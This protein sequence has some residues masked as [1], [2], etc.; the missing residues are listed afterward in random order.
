MIDSI[1]A[2]VLGGFFRT[3]AGVGG[4]VAVIAGSAPVFLIVFIPLMFIY[5][6]IQIYY[7][8]TN[9]ELKRLDATTKSP[10]FASFQETLGGVSTIR[11]YRQSQRFIVENEARIDRNQEAYFPSI[12][13]NRWLA[14]RLEFLGSLIILSTAIIAVFT[15]VRNRSLDAGLVGLMLSY[16]LSTTQ[17]LN[18]M[19]VCSRYLR[20]VQN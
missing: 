5:R 20:I 14:V 8:A 12:N 3:L 6:R 17:T 7:L 1:L 4:M 18:W 11:A 13:A 19:C 10:I 2:R 15:L 16:G 9:R